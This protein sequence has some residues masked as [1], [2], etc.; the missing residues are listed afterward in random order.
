[1]FPK[2][3]LLCNR[4]PSIT[5]ILSCK[6]GTTLAYGDW[7]TIR[8]CRLSRKLAWELVLY[9]RGHGWLDCTVRRIRYHTWYGTWNAAI[10]LAGELGK[11]SASYLVGKVGWPSA[12]SNTSVDPIPSC[13]L[14][15]ISRTISVFSIAL[16]LDVSPFVTSIAVVFLAILPFSFLPLASIILIFVLV[17][18]AAQIF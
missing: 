10:I 6:P 11:P 8:S 13:A 14:S 18:P 3:W 4:F 12:A 1:M 9:V 15:T 5:I 16:I 7:W 17:A 2:T